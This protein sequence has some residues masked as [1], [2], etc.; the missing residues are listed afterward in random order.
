MIRNA[1]KAGIPSVKYNLTLLGV[2]RTGRVT[3]RGGA[4]YSN[5]V[6]ADAKQTPMTIAGEV[7]EAELWDRIT[8]FLKRVVPVAEEAKVRICCHPND[9][10]LARGQSFRGIHCALDTVAGLKRFVETVPSAYHGLNFCQGTISEMLDDPGKEI[11]EVIRWFGTRGKIFNVHFRN[12]RGGYLN[13]Q[14]TFPDNGSVD[15][16]RALKTYQEVGYAGM[17]MPDH[18]P[19]IEG[20]TGEA[21]AFAFCWGYIQAL[22]QQL[23]SGGQA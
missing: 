2:V 7:S 22:L 13:F 12:I 9:P 11:F 3:G 21:Q 20:D 23:K 18:V 5:F 6:Y 15:M 17:V 1:G 4:S 14:E 8:Y 19:Q 16:P 10:G